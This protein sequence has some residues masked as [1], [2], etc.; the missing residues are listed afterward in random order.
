MVLVLAFGLIFAWAEQNTATGKKIAKNVTSVFAK[1][2]VQSARTLSMIDENAAV[3]SRSKSEPTDVALPGQP[4]EQTVADINMKPAQTETGMVPIDEP[5]VK[6]ADHSTDIV[7][8]NYDKSA[9]VENTPTQTI[10]EE[11][12]ALKALIQAES[13]R[14]YQQVYGQKEQQNNAE[15][16]VTASILFAEDFSDAWGLGVPCTTNG[17]AWTVIDSGTEGSHVWYQNA[18]HKWYQSATGW[19][20]T[21]ARS[22]YYSYGTDTIYNTSMI[23][24]IFSSGTATCTLYWK[25]YYYNGST[26]KDSAMVEYTTD[27]GASWTNLV[28]YKATTTPNPKYSTAVIPA[29]LSNVQVG[30]HQIVSGNSTPYY[31]IIDSVRVSVDGS[32]LWI[33]DFNGWGWEGDN[34][35]SGWSIVDSGYYVPKAWNN[36]DWSKRSSMGSQPVAGVTNVTAQGRRERQNEWLITPTITVGTGVACTLSDAEYFYNTSGATWPPGFNWEDYYY[37]WIQEDLGGGSYGPWNQLAF[38]NATRGSTSSKT[39]FKYPLNAWTGKSFRIGYQY[40]NPQPYGSGTFYLDDVTVTDYALTPDDIAATSVLAPSA[41]Y[42]V[43]GTSYPVRGRFT[44]MGGTTETFDVKMVINDGTTDVYADSVLGLSLNVFQSLDT[45]FANFTP[46]TAGLHTFTMTVINPGDAN[47]ANDTVRV[48]KTAY[49]HQGTGGPDAGNYSWIDNTV[50]GGPVFNWVDMSAAT[51]CTLSSYDYGVSRAFPI[52]GSFFY[53]GNVYTHVKISANGVITLDTTQT[54][55][56]DADKPCPNT[57]IP[58]TLLP[59][60]WDDMNGSVGRIRYWDDAANNRFIVEYDS[61]YHYGY[62]AL[63]LDAQIILNRADSSITYQYRNVAANMQTDISIGIENATG[64]IGLAYYDTVTSNLA[65][66]PYS[67]LAIKFYYTAPSLDVAASAIVEPVGTKIVGTPFSP[68]TRVSNFGGVTSFFDVFFEIYNAGGTRVYR[69]SVLGHGLGAGLSDTVTFLPYAAATTGTHRC[70]TWVYLAG[71]VNTANDKITGTFVA[72][73]HFGEGGPDAYLMKWIDNTVVGGPVYAWEE[74]NPDSGGFA[75]ATQLVVTG[76]DDV[77][78]KFY[79]TPNPPFPFYGVNYDS[80]WATSNGLITFGTS[81]TAYSN[82]YIPNSSTP[83]AF[84]APFWD[85]LYATTGTSKIWVLWMGDHTTIQWEGF[86]IGSGGAKTLNFEVLLF[87]D[88]TI[89]AQ[90]K[91]VTGVSGYQGQSATVG[92]ESHNIT[93][94]AVT[95]LQ[96]LYNGTQPS[97]LNLLTNGLA[98]KYYQYVPTLDVSAVSYDAPKGG[99][100]G[101]P[102]FPTVS[103]KNNGTTTTTADVTVKIYGPLPATTQVFNAMETSG[104]IAYG[105]TLPFTFSVNSWTPTAA[106]AYACSVN[107]TTTGDEFASNNNTTGSAMILSTATLPYSTDFEANNGGFLGTN[108]WQWGTPAYASGPAAAHSPVNCWGTDLTGDYNSYA[109][110]I[111]YSPVI[112]L[113]GAP[114]Y[115]LD[116]WMWYRFESI[117][118][119]GANLKIST[120]YGTTWTIL[121]TSVPYTG[122]CTS[123]GNALLY[124]QPGWGGIDT[125]WTP[126][127]VDLTP[128]AGQNVILRFDQGAEGSLQ[129]AGLYIDDFAITQIFADVAVNSIDLPASTSLFPG[130]YQIGA[131]LANLGTTTEIL[132]SVVFSVLD[133]L[134]VEI[135]HEVQTGIS[136]PVGTQPI[137]STGSWTGVLGVYPVTVTAYLA[138]D[139]NTSNN[140]VTKNY[141]VRTL[142]SIPYT[143]PF[144]NSNWQ[145]EIQIWYSGAGAGVYLTTSYVHGTAPDTALYFSYSPY[146][147]DAWIVM[148]PVSLV[149]ATNPRLTFWE[150]AYWWKDDPDEKHLVLIKTGSE[151]NLTSYDT[152]ALY[153][154]SHAIPTRPTW[155]QIELNLSSYIGDTVW[156]MFQMHAVNNGGNWYLD[157][158]MVDE[159]PVIDLAAISIDSPPVPFVNILMSDSYPITA[160]IKNVGGVAVT[161]DSVVFSVTDATPAEVFHN[162]V[163]PSAPI[164]I[165]DSVQYTSSSPWLANADCEFFDITATVYLSTDIASGNDAYTYPYGY[166]VENLLPTPFNEEFTAATMACWLSFSTPG[167]AGLTS[168]RS[169]SPTTSYVFVGGNVDP[170]DNIILSPPISLVGMSQPRLTFWESANYWL[171]DPDEQH[172]IYVS[173]GPVNTTSGFTPIAVFDTS[174]YIPSGGTGTPFQEVTVDLSAY[175]GDTVW[176]WI[177]YY[178]TLNG[179]NWYIDDFNVSETP[180]DMAALSIIEPVSPVTEGVSFTPTTEV[181]NLGIAN[182]TYDVTFEIYDGSGVIHTETITGLTLDAGLVDTIE[183]TP[184]A[185]TPAGAYT[186]TTYVALTGDINPANDKIGMALTVNSAGYEYMPG[187]ANMEVAAWPPSV[188]AADVTRLISFF[189]GNVGACLFYNPSAP[190]TELWA[191]ADVNGNCEVRGSDATRLVTYLKGT[192]GTA[193]STCEYYPAVTPIQANYPACTPV[194]PA[195]AI[196]NTPT[197]NTE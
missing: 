23:T 174:H 177:E 93:A 132:D 112:A 131:T 164:A 61:L 90:Y 72:D 15:P 77:A 79:I 166:A 138:S 104:P 35:P 14:I 119:D 136:L 144:N 187:D 126:V 107:V 38:V 127:N 113:T 33:Q 20:D 179:G 100:V 40:I 98:I 84:I 96:Y 163:I 117:S 122:T 19:N 185:I 121:N 62:S 114:R 157:D 139:G 53:Y 49:V 42:M 95:G 55:I 165:G 27:G 154:T 137:T 59:V 88:G 116:F 12:P 109:S 161:P 25:E 151:F 47:A 73:M 188:G 194:A 118:Y 158:I 123:T 130:S 1:R 18:W 108:E 169:H 146:P 75:G 31:W 54:S 180:R 39:I 24:P 103:V 13:D 156:V 129:Y 141:R 162:V 9:E 159:T 124:G 66:L 195:K 184:Y 197:G 143:E 170:R 196:K 69:D 186:C 41:S 29:G 67:G 30:F 44:N 11:N 80:G 60:Y 145:N 128:Y 70:T 63:K 94:D 115:S 68:A 101:T 26:T 99:I 48:T 176:F 81:S 2:S 82:T 149:G 91:D 97:A 85:D 52:G 46:A 56:P 45:A 76:G 105:A 125:V 10:D 140:S 3:A 183:F 83:N 160:T 36:N 120:D 58:N 153:D 34:P 78:Y 74:L 168:S 182:E 50:V 178:S 111:L 17:A 8:D 92:I 102:Y 32:I 65:N 133:P 43:A 152:L 4:V 6:K 148:A 171:R 134:A 28:K 189:K 22:M 16:P 142:E 191:S 37:I 86:S 106:G 173:T 181:A 190:V 64:T 167:T 135:F 147:R 87:V 175:V 89:I 155:Q 7:I 71:D 150:T 21:V 57:T 193:P 110:N 192:P 51:V 172:I 5:Y